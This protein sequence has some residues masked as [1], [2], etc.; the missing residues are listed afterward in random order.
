MIYKKLKEY[1]PEKIHLVYS[2]I[3]LTIISSA[4]MAASYWHL[5]KLLNSLLVEK[6][7]V[8][9]VNIAG[10][11][12]GFLIAN[13]I[14]Y[15][16][17]LW[18]TH[19]VAFRLETNLKK[20]G[21]DNL[22]GASFS[23]YDKNESGRIRKII[24]DNT[25]LT[26]MSVAHL[27]P[28]LA[29]AVFTPLFSLIL[30]FV[31]DYR[32]GILFIIT[33][34]IGGI[35]GKGMMGETEFMG[36]YMLAQE[37]MT[38]GAVEYVRGMSV[39]KIFKANVRSLKEF[40]NSILDYSEMAL[41]YSMSCRVPY[42]V[43][44]MF[45]NSIILILIP[46]SIYVISR[47]ENIYDIA[48]KVI[49]YVSMCGVIFNAF[50]KIMYVAMYQYQA[51]SAIKKIEDLFTDMKQKGLFHGEVKEIEN[52]DITF[53]NVSF[54]YEENMILNNLS[55]YLKQGK[56]YALVG[57]SGSGK[58]TIVKLISGFYPVNSGKVLI[59]GHSID[60]YTEDAIVK[61]IANVFQDS[62]LFK[63][64]I[65]D[66]V[67]V[68]NKEATREEVMEAL[69]LAQCDEIL[70]KF[71]ERENVVIGTKGVYLSGGET[72][73]IAI[74]RAILKDAKIIILDEASA[75]ADPENEY[76]LQKAFA[77]LMKGKT[78]IMIAH[79]LSSIRNVDEIL[80]VQDGKI[81]ERGNDAELMA[82]DS[83]YRSYQEKFRQANDWKVKK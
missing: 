23:F 35:I 39:L 7:V 15:F 42:V 25:A 71:K 53:E 36:K 40:Y 26:H 22:M 32:L 28:D 24:D 31:V 37:K 64:S 11:I 45:F 30:A 62:K 63:M 33:V 8:D 54:G 43:F 52:C 74:A 83:V 70:D 57:A 55:F 47:G 68:G 20:R 65:F 50:M 10:C 18:C 82:K 12:L 67:K 21:I 66:N 27:I 48:A 72:Q 60:E 76:E 73:R 29:T 17:S 56:T 13:A 19:L 34:I 59:G 5:Y 78:V 77:N 58:S 2:G 79:R 9:A 6:K 75:A 51:T 4:C 61:N 1:V 38:S 44:Q 14:V 41:S 80:V 69:H 3:L 46:A 16:I 49:F 81:I